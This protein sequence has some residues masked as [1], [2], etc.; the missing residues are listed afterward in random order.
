MKNS[1]KRSDERELGDMKNSSPITSI[2]GDDTDCLRSRRHSTTLEVVHRH[3]HEKLVPESGV[4]DG[5]DF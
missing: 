3:E 5:A 4:E 1:S 2:S